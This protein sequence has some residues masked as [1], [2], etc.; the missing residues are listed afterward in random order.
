MWQQSDS[1]PLNLPST[2]LF[3]PCKTNTPQGG[4]TDVILSVPNQFLLM[5]PGT[6]KEFPK[7]KPNVCSVVPFSVYFP[8]NVF[9]ESYWDMNGE[10]TFTLRGRT[11]H[12]KSKR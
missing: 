10:G 4:E 5:G 11:V 2:H 3:L 1:C 12:E 6:G 9:F 7:M 8:P